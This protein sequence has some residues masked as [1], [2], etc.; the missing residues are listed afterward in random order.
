MQKYTTRL[1]WSSIALVLW[2]L[3][4]SCSKQLDQQPV[5][6]ATRDAIFANESGLQLY[7]NS[8]Y[9]VLPGMGDVFR[10]DAMSDYAAVN[11][12]PD[13]LRAGAYN[14]RVQAEIDNWKFTDLRNINYFIAN[15]NNP[16]L[17]QEVR[18]NYTGLARFFRAVFYFNKVKRYGDVPWMG[19][20]AA[21]S[22]S[23]MLYKARDSRQLVMDSI[24]ADLDFAAAHITRNVDATASQ[25]T[26]YVVYGFKSRICLFEGTYR[27][28]H[29]I[30]TNGDDVTLLQLAADAAQKVMT[31]GGFALSQVGGSS[32]AYRN[33][34]ISAAPVAT[35]VMLSNVTSSSLSVFNDANWYYTSATYGARLNFTRKF[36]NTYLNID[37]TPF[38]SIDGHDTLPFAKE[39][40]NRDLRLKQTIRTP[41][42]TRTENGKVVA[43]P[44][45]FSYTYTGYM[46]IKWSLEDLYY[47]AGANNT[48]SIC[49]MRYA[50]ILLNYAEA[51][52]ELG[53]LSA[54]DW[55]QTVGALRARAGITGG[56]N[57]LPTVADPYLVANY[58]VDG[59]SLSAVILEVRRERAIELS[60]E[61]FRYYDLVRWAQ[62][63]L[64][65]QQWNGMYVPALN[66]PMDL[67]SDGKN[68][69]CFYTTEPTTKDDG[70]TYI[71]V[72]GPT[73]KLSNGTYGELKW[74][75]N[76]DRV[77]FD[78]SDNNSY[79]Y[80]YPL[81]YAE[82]L[83]NPKLQQNPKWSGQ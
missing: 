30:A 14:E 8:F 29:G 44:P 31:E 64:L 62:G 16:V 81:P 21:V 46:P 24:I 13:F 43:A 67:N 80:L 22:D 41:G 11:A 48:N 5:S 42:Y 23:A 33:L 77:A 74:L 7:A 71:N 50:E 4:G 26:K 10:A 39:T 60:L 32:M 76:I 65:V 53:T 27:R 68:D 19:T 45:V 61:G 70:V 6:T 40:Q 82:L 75:D 55:A 18:D 57:T 69:V 66:I 1:K 3:A 58:T 79:R 2:V 78:N 35:E 36:I 28:Y 51:K 34:F 47:D 59:E 72:S 37:G 9:N 12:V 73:T 20:P 38:T 63:N 83:L 56:L 15:N 49:L 54:A 17:S 52:A 25:I